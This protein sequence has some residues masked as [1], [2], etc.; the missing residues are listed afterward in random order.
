MAISSAAS[1]TQTASIATEH[2]LT[3]QSTA[4]RFQLMVNLSNLVKGDVVIIRVKVKVLSSGSAA[5]IVYGPFADVVATPIV[6]TPIIPSLYSYEAT[7]QQTAGTGRNFEW[8]LIE[9]PDD[10]IN[11]DTYA[12]PGQGAP[13]ATTTLAAKINYLYKAWR[14]KSTQTSTTYSLFA[15]DAATVDQKATVSDDATTFTKGEV[16]TGP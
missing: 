8:N 1:G 14:N 10:A 3:T 6:V 7:L 9:I 15:D 4:R 16:A 5:E 12:E 2:S 11:S 13:A